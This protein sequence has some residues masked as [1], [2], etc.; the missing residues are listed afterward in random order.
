M[1]LPRA[2]KEAEERANALIQAQ[3][4]REGTPEETT[5]PAPEPEPGP[6]VTVTESQPEPPPAEA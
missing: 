4:K 1:E 2:V 3:G 5:P 6:E